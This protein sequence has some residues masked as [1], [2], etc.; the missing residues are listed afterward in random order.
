MQHRITYIQGKAV[1]ILLVC[2]LIPAVMPRISVKAG[3]RKEVKVRTGIDVL[4]SRDFDVI[5]GKRVGLITN[6]TGIDSKGKS[7]IDILAETDKTKLV[8]IFA[9]EHGVRGEA[10]AGEK[11][12]SDRDTKTGLP[13]HSLYGKTLKPTR[14]ML[15]GIDVLVYD[16]QDVGVRFY[17]YISTMAYAMEAAREN[18]LDFVV[19]DRPNPIGGMAIEGPI[20]R[21]EFSSFVGLY[22]IPVRYGMTIGELARLFNE[23]FGIRAQLKV[24]EMEGWQRDM[25][26]DDTG[27]PWIKPSPN[28]PT[29][30]SA[31][32]YPG[33]CFIE[34]F[35]NVS[36]GRGTDHPF[37][38]IGAPWIDGEALA[39][40]LD[41]MRLPGVSF[42]PC[43]FT[44]KS[45]KNAGKRCSGIEVSVKDRSRFEPVATGLYIVEAIV[46]M[47]PAQATWAYKGSHFDRLIGTD[48]VR[49]LLEGEEPASNIINS[50]ASEIAEFRRVR[51]N[52]LL[53]NLP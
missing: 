26:F 27:L 29:L 16:I 31:T 45:S 41:A 51:E 1:I 5:A 7:T 37:E 22:P 43:E 36:E 46:S 30:D 12:S 19:L 34:G 35:V 48:K 17:T 42:S 32:V 11:V 50:W 47:Y 10:E 38:W 20:L 39:K 24:V 21:K 53:Y 40:R 9:P 44:P 14:E 33:T 4:A 52:Y 8:A 28:I 6:H 15:Q 23:E 2:L 18:G 25:W 13:I 3:G 49:H